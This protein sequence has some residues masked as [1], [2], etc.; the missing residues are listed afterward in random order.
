VAS[1][2][3]TAD[4]DRGAREGEGEGEG[5]GL[6]Y[7][8]HG[9]RGDLTVRGEEVLDAAG[10]LVHVAAAGRTYVAC[11]LPLRYA[12]DIYVV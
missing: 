8:A 6:P 9:D 10:S 7:L 2:G 5:G 1:Q 4:A 3:C 11:P 12:I